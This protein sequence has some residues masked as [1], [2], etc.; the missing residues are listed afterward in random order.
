MTRTALNQH[1]EDLN[2]WI[3]GEWTLTAAPGTDRSVIVHAYRCT[4]RRGSFH[5]RY[6]LLHTGD[7]ITISMASTKVNAH[8]QTRKVRRLLEN[9]QSRQ[10]DI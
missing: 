7:I 9:I 2:R 5:G 8:M 3:F 1:D 4:R 10:R 6:A